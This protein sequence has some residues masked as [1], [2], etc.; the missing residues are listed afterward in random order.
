MKYIILLISFLFLYACGNN[1]R[2]QGADATAQDEE[3]K[4]EI[5]PSPRV[6]ITYNQPIN[7][8]NVLITWFPWGGISEVGN[9]FIEFTH[10]SGTPR[11]TIASSHFTNL[12]TR[13]LA[14][15]LQR[16]SDGQEF[17]L[18]YTP[19]Q[20]RTNK[21]L[22]GYSPLFF[23]DVDFDGQDE[24][25]ITEW[26]G[27]AKGSSSFEAYKIHDYYAEKLT[28]MPF[29]YITGSDKYDYQAKTITRWTASGAF[30]TTREVYGYHKTELNVLSSL[31]NPLSSFEEDLLND[32]YYP[33]RL[34]SVF[35]WENG[36]E[37]VYARQEN[38][39]ILI[40]KYTYTE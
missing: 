39:L 1:N 9:A 20:T 24:L 23:M 11:F 22:D 17:V 32:F 33:I 37:L 31:E 5:N 18:N 8:Y 36:R 15:S 12:D 30:F 35:I 14:D 26:Q 4:E 19:P 40:R 16:F 29:D 28:R 6:Y 2:R 10:Q 34:D 38:K 13:I 21:M 25:L 7:G 3:Q 27:G